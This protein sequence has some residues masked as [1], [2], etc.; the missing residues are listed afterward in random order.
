M[1]LIGMGGHGRDIANVAW[2]RGEHVE[3]LT[4][5]TQF[6]GRV[7][8]YT[9]AINNPQ[10]RARAATEVGFVDETWI[11]PDARCFDSLIGQG[12]HVNYGVRMTRTRIGE[13]ATI[14]P[15]VTICGDVIIGDRVLIG[16]GATICDRVV[17]E[18]DAVIGAA[19][20]VLP[21]RIVHS[22]ETVVGVP[23]RVL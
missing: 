23:A 18:D 12:T 22:G 11:H 10:V 4:H 19:A 1:I 15:G 20:C 6:I 16:A 9:L 17:I 21:A 7:E 8:S 2:A 14:S 5:H 3:W 13:H